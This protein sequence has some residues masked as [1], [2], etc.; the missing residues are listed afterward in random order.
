MEKSYCYTWEDWPSLETL[1]LAFPSSPSVVISGV[2]RRGGGATVG[3]GRMWTSRALTPSGIF[4]CLS[5]PLPRQEQEEFRGP[6]GRNRETIVRR[7]REC[8]D[9]ET[10]ED[11]FL[12]GWR[13]APEA[14]RQG[15]DVGW[16]ERPWRSQLMT[17]C[18]GD[19]E[20]SHVRLAPHRPLLLAGNRDRQCVLPLP[21]GHSPPVPLIWTLLPGSSL[22]SCCSFSL[23]SHHSVP[24]GCSPNS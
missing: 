12:S 22:S 20:V 15:K 19:C 5:G 18:W 21:S 3:P 13:L 11:S 10:E 2:L 1:I 17:S 8:E 7:V 16:T 4:S 6:D 14:W 23:V 9:L 24:C